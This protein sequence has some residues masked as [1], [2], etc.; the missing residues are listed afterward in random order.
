MYLTSIILFALAA[1]GGIVLVTRRLQERPL[2]MWLAIL[3]GVL[4][5]T[6]LTLLIIGVVMSDAPPSLLQG[7]IIVFLLAALGGLILFSMHLQGKALPIFLMFAH[8]IIAVAAFLMFLGA[9]GYLR[10]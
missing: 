2:P 3:H 8:G 9:M 4:A 1:L 10:G 6:G 5:A 7:A